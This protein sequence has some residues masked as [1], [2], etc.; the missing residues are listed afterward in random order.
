MPEKATNKRFFS[1]RENKEVFEFPRD[2][3]VRG[4]C[5]CR[6]HRRSGARKVR[7][8]DHLG[9]PRDEEFGFGEEVVRTELAGYGIGLRVFM[10]CSVVILI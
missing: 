9:E 2:Y 5:P 4:N 8:T 1:S 3:R 7:K 6:Y 10:L